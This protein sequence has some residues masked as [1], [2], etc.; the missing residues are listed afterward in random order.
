MPLNAI[1]IKREWSANCKA[2][3]S[4]EMLQVVAVQNNYGQAQDVE[5]LVEGYQHF[6]QDKYTVPQIICAIRKCVLKKSTVPTPHEIAEV[7]DP[8][9]PKVTYS[10]YMHAVKMRERDYAGFERGGYSQVINDYH[11]QKD[12]QND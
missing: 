5:F 11:N 1:A 8:P 10:E 12:A 3:L 2:L 6:L 9:A 4:E 7:I